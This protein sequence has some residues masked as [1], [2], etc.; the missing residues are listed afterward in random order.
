VIHRSFRVLAVLALAAVGIAASP[1]RPAGPHANWNAAVTT[2]D[3]GVYTVGNPAAKVRLTE[4]VSYTCPHCAHFHAEGDAALRL[5]YVPQ[6]KVAITVQQ[7]L[8]NPI[9]V[10]VALLT[11]CGDP[12]SFFARHNAFFASQ[13]RWL[14]KV[15]S[16][17][18]AQTARW[19]TGA[20]ADR[21]R[22]IASDL[23]F[24]DT[25]AHWGVSRPQA[26]RC[27]ADAAMLKRL[28]TQTEQA[29]ELGVEST[30]SFAINGTVLAG[31]HD[32][33]LLAPQIDAA[34]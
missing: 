12:R 11:N 34:L 3:N 13:E 29:M 2:G 5:T 32:W 33:R 22:A 25:V 19:S 10:T 8:R 24:Y 16:L 20:P 28:T 7:I 9:D 27:L 6:G 14:A 30:P 1:P 4:Y 18:E 26:D 17:T 31:T 23:A 21:F 15:S